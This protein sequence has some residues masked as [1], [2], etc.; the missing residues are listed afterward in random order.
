MPNVSKNVLIAAAAALVSVVAI[1]ILAWWAGTAPP[2]L[3]P[4]RPATVAVEPGKPETPATAAGSV[5]SSAAPAG[6]PMPAPAPSQSASSSAPGVPLP[7]APAPSFDVVRVEPSGDTV[8]AGRAAPGTTVTLMSSGQPVGTATADAGGQFVI[9]P[10]P[11]KP[12]AQELSLTVR[13]P[14]GEQQSLQS[15]AVSIPQKG[16]K[17][18]VI[19]ALAE[20]G[21]PTQILSDPK[22]AAKPAAPAAPG[23]TP[24]APAPAQ[25][26]TAPAKPPQTSAPQAPS[27]QPPQ[28]AFRTVEIEQGSGFF[29]TGSA[30]AGA[31][32]RIYLNDAHVADVTAA[33]NGQWSLR[34][35]RGLP[36]GKYAVRADQI[37]PANGGVVARAEVPFAVT[38]QLAAV[39]PSGALRTPPRASDAAP[40]AQSGASLPATG[41]SGPSVTAAP[42]NAPETAKP[43][44]A[45]PSSPATAGTAAAPTAR[46]AA[47]RP[48]TAKPE[49]AAPVPPAGAATPASRAAAVPAPV[50]PPPAPSPPS[51]PASASQRPEAVAAVPAAADPS[52]VTI[53]Q[54]T[55]A[56]V[57]RGDSLWRISRKMLGRGIRYTQ[58]YDANTTQIRDPRR[59]YPGQVLVVPKDRET[60]P[61]SP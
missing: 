27:A 13:G 19:V 61:K 39:E 37:D 26:P 51:A 54:L 58:I 29:A 33:Q 32:L 30:T 21:K 44:A 49:A 59:I 17:D 16:S 31:R 23:A 34:I 40:P 36:A 9:I 46:T 8:V 38:P 6:S 1:A 43:V 42:S 14:S 56:T 12:G 3:P 15:V 28:V 41:A 5:P 24:S 18:E 57:V 48:E 20:P 60:P 35:T 11:L 10:G 45:P 53:D 2:P 55:T 50:N 52:N 7:A 47:V 22:P 4:Q 25:Q